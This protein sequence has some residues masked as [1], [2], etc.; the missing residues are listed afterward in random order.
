M[1]DN[2][3]FDSLLEDYRKLQLRV[4]RFSNTE[5]ELIN[6]RDRLDQEL[7]QYKR[8]SDFNSAALKTTDTK[9]LLAL[10][11][12]AI[13]DIFEVET[14]YVFEKLSGADQY[15]HLFHDGI[16]VVC[17]KMRPLLDDIEVVSSQTQGT[18]A[19]REGLNLKTE[20]HY[21]NQF[22]KAIYF[23]YTDVDAGNTLLIIGMVSVKNEPLY[24]KLE[25]RQDSIYNVFGQQVQS[26]LGNIKKSEQIQQQINTISASELELKK[27]SLIAT[28]T[29]NGV[30]ITDNQ[31]RI[32]WANDSFSESSGFSL[33][34]VIGKKPKEFLHGPE[35]DDNTR[36]ILSEALSKKKNVE[37][38]LLNYHKS[39]SRYYNQLEITPVLDEQGNL[40]NF[41]SLQKDITDEIRAKEEILRINSR[42]EQIAEK[43]QIGIWEREFMDNTIVWNDILMN[44]YGVKRNETKED[45]V[46]VWRTCVHPDDLQYVL[47]SQQKLYSKEAESVELEYRIKRIN[48]GQWRYLKTLTIAETDEQGELQ[49]LIGSSVDITETRLSQEKL[50]ASEE[51]YRR[52]IENMNLGLIETN[53]NGELIFMNELFFKN[54]SILHPQHLVLGQNPEL[55]LQQR[56]IDKDIVSFRKID[57]EVFEIEILDSEEKALHLLV[58]TGNVL[59]QSSKT[60]GYINIILDISSEKQLN[61][62]FERALAER[63]SYLKEVDTLKQ[64]YENV[65]NNSPAKIAVITPDLKVAFYNNLLAEQEPAW[66]NSEGKSIKGLLSDRQDFLSKIEASLASLKLV[67]LEEKMTYDNG[68]DKYILRNILPHVNQKN[69]LEYLVISGVN[70]SELKEIQSSVTTKN[71][72]LKKI[73]TEL[74]NFVYS[75]SH[76][77][78]S[79]LLAIKGL[80]NLIFQTSSLDKNVETYLKLAEDSVL[81]LDSTIQEILDYSRNARLDLELK[82]VDLAKL[83]EPIFADLKFSAPEGIELEIEIDGNPRIITDETRMSVLLKNIIGNAV[84]YRRNIPE[85]F[86]KVHISHGDTS[87]FIRIEDNG[88]GI[89][90][91]SLTKVFDMFYRGTSE[92]IG[93]GLGLYLCKEIVDKFGG[94]LSVNSEWGQGSTF[95]IEHPHKTLAHE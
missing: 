18:G 37:V 93:T 7:V 24:R 5:Q 63:D 76:D 79:P 12:E 80:I 66:A 21:L 17:D 90:Q 75:V 30:I 23:R 70:I 52:I 27:L 31:G 36:E 43:S 77:L 83:V 2:P 19:I 92:S 13:V 73:N 44:Q 64:F 15:L 6:T 11:S 56:V 29:K 62:N 86:V 39:G 28:K 46:A 26:L 94:K 48:D 87:T 47:D 8:M 4:T 68:E 61:I 40:L 9:Q 72:E 69:E 45:L 60:S 25:P 65:L 20:L 74:D 85:A 32:E 89:T 10:T 71:E 1:L 81:R 14:A 34:E 84:K 3:D 88:Q 16:E 38:T 49:R 91:K 67:Q 95:I 54:T 51:K 53:L 55:A 42:F 35:T 59:N 41:I 82:E 58:S 22:A 33:D 57:D 50:R 78:R